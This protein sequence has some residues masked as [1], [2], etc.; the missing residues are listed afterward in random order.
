MKNKIPYSSTTGSFKKRKNCYT[1][2]YP[3][4]AAK[5]RQFLSSVTWDYDTKVCSWYYCWRAPYTIN[6]NEL[7]KRVWWEMKRHFNCSNPICIVQQ[8]SKER[9]CDSYLYTV[10]LYC[11]IPNIPSDEDLKLFETLC[12]E[13][14]PA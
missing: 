2:Y 4:Q 6:T 13:S 11:I 14:Q 7:R 3:N 8:Q 10:E 12:K 1:Y 9:H 5:V